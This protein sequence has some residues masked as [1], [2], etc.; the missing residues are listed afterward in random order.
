MHLNCQEEV[1]IK[2]EKGA[3]RLLSWRDGSSG[4]IWLEARGH[5]TVSLIINYPLADKLWER[6]IGKKS[7]S[8]EENSKYSIGKRPE[9]LIWRKESSLSH[10]QRP[11]NC[12]SPNQELRLKE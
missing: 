1:V 6:K 12:V 9:T 11:R 2:Q 4:H 10:H 7:E 5:P 8:W 3:R